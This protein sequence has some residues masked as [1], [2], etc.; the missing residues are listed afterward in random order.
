VL[1]EKLIDRKVFEMESRVLRQIEDQTWERVAA[2]VCDY[3]R[4]KIGSPIYQQIEIQVATQI[5]N[6]IKNRMIQV[7]TIQNQIKNRMIQVDT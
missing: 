4:F 3:V 7:D 6:Q 2:N 5:Q 1:H